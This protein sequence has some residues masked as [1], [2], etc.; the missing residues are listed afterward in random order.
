MGHSKRQPH[1]CNH[2]EGFTALPV[3]KEITPTSEENFTFRC[4]KCGFEITHNFDVTWT[5]AF[6]LAWK[7]IANAPTTTD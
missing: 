6:D 1:Y 4:W 7:T 3:A 2:C 5:K